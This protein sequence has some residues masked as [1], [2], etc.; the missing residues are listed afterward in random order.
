MFDWERSVVAP[1]T[2]LIPD[3][4]TVITRPRLAE[5]ILTLPHDQQSQAL[6][7]RLR[8]YGVSF[9]NYAAYPAA[10]PVSAAAITLRSF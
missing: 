4:S 10:L 6:S 5:R 3:Y 7:K 9:Y 8:L 2:R 1:I